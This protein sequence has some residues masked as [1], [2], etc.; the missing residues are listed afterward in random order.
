MSINRFVDLACCFLGLEYSSKLL[1]H[2]QIMIYSIQRYKIIDE[3]SL[4]LFLQRLRLWPQ[5]VVMS[6][7]L[8]FVPW[9]KLVMLDVKVHC[10]SKKTGPLLR[11]EITPT[12]C[13]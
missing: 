4:I 8:N 11:F 3:L 9:C 7:G 2:V 5:W 10:V 1:L 6:N 12:N 13:A